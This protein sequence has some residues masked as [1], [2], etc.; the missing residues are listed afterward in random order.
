MNCI[1]CCKDSKEKRWHL[2][3]FDEEIEKTFGKEVYDILLEQSIIAQKNSIP[4]WI[5][6]L[7]AEGVDEGRR[8]I[9]RFRIYATLFLLRFDEKEIRAKI[10]E[11]NK[12]CRPPENER[13]VEY[14]CRYF[15]RRFF[16]Q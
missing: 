11:F 14:H 5:E 4:A 10:F 1:F 6:R 16:N 12:N 9:T 3:C 15:E 7:V 13:E 2:D 8:N